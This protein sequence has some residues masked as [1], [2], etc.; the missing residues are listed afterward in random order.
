MITLCQAERITLQSRYPVS[1]EVPVECF[2]SKVKVL[3]PHVEPYT[4]VLNDI[5]YWAVPAKYSYT[6]AFV[7]L[8]CPQVIMSPV[9]LFRAFDDFCPCVPFQHNLFSGLPSFRNVNLS[10]LEYSVL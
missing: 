3:T 6:G 1:R 8:L 7:V 10:M 2:Q 9:D 5:T 4:L